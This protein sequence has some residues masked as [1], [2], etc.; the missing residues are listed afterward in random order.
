MSRQIPERPLTT[1]VTPRCCSCLEEK[2][3]STVRLPSLSAYI[4]KMNAS[5]IQGNK[6]LTVVLVAIVLITVFDRLITELHW[7]VTEAV[8]T[9]TQTRPVRVMCL[10]ECTHDAQS[11][12]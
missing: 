5:L 11:A 4:S 2:H 12:H 6:S 1:D 8:V 9:H 10:S 3:N 7:P